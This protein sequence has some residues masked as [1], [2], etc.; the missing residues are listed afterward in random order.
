[1]IDATWEHATRN[2]LAFYRLMQG[3]KSIAA[4]VR[5]NE[6]RAAIIATGDLTAEVIG[7][8]LELNKKTARDMLA[9]NK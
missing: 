5:D 3:G 9:A 6:T 2:G 4:I 7:D 8:T 1:M